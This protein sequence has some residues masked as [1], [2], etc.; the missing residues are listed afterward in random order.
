[1]T[2]IVTAAWIPSI[3][4]GSDMRATPPSRRMSAGTRSSAITAVAPAS[5]AIF[6]WWASTTSMIT[7]PRSISASPRFTRAVPTSEFWEGSLMRPMLPGARSRTRSDCSGCH[8]DGV[9]HVREFHPRLP[10]AQ[11]DGLARRVDELHRRRLVG[12]GPRPGDHVAVGEDLHGPV[13]DQLRLGPDVAEPGAAVDD[14]EHHHVLRRDLGARLRGERARTRGAL[15]GAR[16]RV[17]GVGGGELLVGEGDVHR[18]RGAARRARV[19]G[20]VEER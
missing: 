4:A 12:A 8:L 14:G 11:G 9:A 1:M 17:P 13:P 10:R 3:I 19:G 18:T 16:R 5:S 15:P 2:G 20:V 7:P 6:A